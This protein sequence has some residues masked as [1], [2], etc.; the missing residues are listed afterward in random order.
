MIH[1][2]LYDKILF[3]IKY[4]NDKGNKKLLDNKKLRG[5]IINSKL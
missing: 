3:C 1:A 4:V 5:E 2:K